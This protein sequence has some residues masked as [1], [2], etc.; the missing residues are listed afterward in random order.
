MYKII[1]IHWGNKYFLRIDFHGLLDCS[2]EPPWCLPGASLVP[3]WCVF[4][5]SLVP[6]CTP[7][8]GP[9]VLFEHQKSRRFS[10]KFATGPP[11]LPLAPHKLSRVLLEPIFQRLW[12]Q[13]V[14][15]CALPAPILMCFSSQMR[16]DCPL[17]RQSALKVT[18]NPSRPLIKSLKFI[19]EMYKIIKIHWGNEYFLRIDFHTPKTTP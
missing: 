7:W 2:L 17:W 13:K 4:G 16:P 3:P 8:L 12:A 10:L 14:F 6:P 15:N 18:P 1:K 11:M 9:R 19:G 5:A